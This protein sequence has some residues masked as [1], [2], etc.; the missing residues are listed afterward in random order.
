[1]SE[2]HIMELLTFFLSPIYAILD[3]VIIVPIILLACFGTAPTKAKISDS[4][5]SHGPD[6]RS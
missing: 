1:M 5:D 4:A 3:L 6:R 2:V